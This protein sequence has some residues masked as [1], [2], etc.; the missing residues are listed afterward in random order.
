MPAKKTVMVLTV[1]S[2]A[3]RGKDFEI[4]AKGATLGRKGLSLMYYKQ[5][6]QLRFPEDEDRVSHKHATISKIGDG[7][8]D[9]GIRDTGSLNGTWLDGHRLSDERQ[10][11]EV[12][13]LVD[14]SV[15][16]VGGPPDRDNT[17]NF[18]ISFREVESKLQ[19]PKKLADR[20]SAGVQK[21]RKWYNDT[22]THLE[23]GGS[24]K[25]MP[26]KPGMIPVKQIRVCDL[27]DDQVDVPIGFSDNN[28][29]A[30]RAREQLGLSTDRRDAPSRPKASVYDRLMPNTSILTKVVAQT[31]MH[32]KI[33]EEDDWEKEVYGKP[34]ALGQHLAGRQTAPRVY[35][36][37]GIG[38]G[39]EDDLMSK[40]IADTRR[41][42]DSDAASAKR[43]AGAV[44]GPS[45]K[46][47]RVE[48][49][50]WVTE[51]ATAPHPPAGLPPPVALPIVPTEW[52]Q[53]TAPTGH[54]YWYNSLT[55]LS[56]W[57]VPLPGST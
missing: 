40:M 21:W 29:L 2:K 3:H 38:H 57:E 52:Q 31:V 11:S 42:V 41:Q 20:R 13:P 33:R 8:A 28:S 4:G 37:G 10:K 14:G 27:R 47:A 23:Q 17:Y 53:H 45:S 12:K 15:L 1:T 5:L 36:A 39:H 48:T 19:P 6:G 18:R 24:A 35:E 26:T 34:G 55:G 16:N 51:K 25:D 44:E 9:F 49:V 50:A 46:R 56:Q 30:A 43:D 54:L 7:P 32:N 22:T